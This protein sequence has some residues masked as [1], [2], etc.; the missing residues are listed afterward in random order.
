MTAGS[1]DSFVHLHVHTE[2]S[3]LDGA[4]RLGEMF[5]RTAELGMDAIAMTDH[6]NVFGAYD[7][8]SKAKA[9]GVKPIIG[10]ESYLTPN[11]SRFDRKRVR[12]NNGGTDDV[13]GSGAYT[14]MTLLAE[15]TAGM[16][17]LFRLSSRSFIE[18]FFYKPR[19]DRELLA[20]YAEGL[21]GTTGCPSG[22]IQTWLRIGDY[23]KARAAAGEFQD[24]FGKDSFFLELMDHGLDIETQVR[25][26][27]LR[28]SKD[29][30][31]PPVATN[32][33]H[34]TNA[35]DA[36]AHEHLLCV[37][38]GSTM[39][40]PKRFKFDGDSYYI[41]SPAEMR[42]LWADK[43]D[44]P[45]ACDNTLLIAE[46]CNVE[47]DENANYMPRF[48]VPEGETEDSWFVKEV[49]KGLNYR[50]PDG[51]PDVVRKQA[52]FEIGVITQMGFPG[53]FL[54]VA[55]FINWAKDNGIRVGPGRGSGGGSM[56]L[57]W[58]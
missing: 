55:D 14:H 37:S 34:Y 54:V 42:A 13:S 39:A 18:G 35:E 41:K 51:V 38:S 30:G 6:G 25:E 24:I 33:S 31:I 9:A 52:D 21:I 58:K 56:A 49:E 23:E 36:A 43:Y 20:E 32:D 3:M 26:G 47:F 8:Y 27:L 22:E 10:M 46:R 12:W 57:A 1:S 16:H 19:A 28:L 2:Y 15:T 53:Y 50:Y 5:A 17:N 44:L 7:F 11:T 40:D 48:P 4:A 45:E 29:L